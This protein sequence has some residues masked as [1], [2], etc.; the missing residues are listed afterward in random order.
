MDNIFSENCEQDGL[1]VDMESFERFM[2]ALIDKICIDSQIPR[3]ILTKEETK[4]KK[5]SR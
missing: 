5:Y 2:D 3:S 1:E 4:W